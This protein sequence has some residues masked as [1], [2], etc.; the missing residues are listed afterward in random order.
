MAI[1]QALSAARVTSTADLPIVSTPIGCKWNGVT[2]YSIVIWVPSLIFEP[3]LC[4]L[5]VW[6]AWGKDIQEKGN[7]ADEVNN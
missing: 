3:I 1:F 4:I 2:T 6:K 7:A 5:V